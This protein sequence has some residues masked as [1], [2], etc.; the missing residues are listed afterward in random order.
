MI[1][2]SK[3]FFISAS[4]GQVNIDG[5]IY[6]AISSHSPMYKAMAGKKKGEK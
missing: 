1:T 5:E 3:K 4:L 2:D 6:I